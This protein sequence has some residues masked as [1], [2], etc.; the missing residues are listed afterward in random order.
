MKK[1]TG[2]P[3]NEAAMLVQGWR[4]DYTPP[5]QPGQLFEIAELFEELKMNGIKVRPARPAG[6]EKK[7]AQREN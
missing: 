7:K 5:A 1:H 4:L 3:L 6:E 2:L